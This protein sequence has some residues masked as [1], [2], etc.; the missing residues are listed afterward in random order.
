MD[1]STHPSSWWRF[2][3]IGE[4][5]LRDLM[6]SSTVG[7]QGPHGRDCKDTSTDHLP[8]FSKLQ[9][10]MAALFQPAESCY[11][12]T[13]LIAWPCH[14]A[15]HT[16][17]APDR[18]LNCV[19]PTN[20]ARIQRPL[21]KCFHAETLSRTVGISINALWLTARSCSTRKCVQPGHS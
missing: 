10:D 21:L 17:S 9:A 3:K 19:V 20:F 16:T 4:I 13:W 6:Q 8:L 15:A 1:I 7:S 18:P 12:S 11:L 5:L 14:H 2:S